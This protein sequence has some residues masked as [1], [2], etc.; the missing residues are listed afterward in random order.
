M[1]DQDVYSGFGL[2]V[3]SVAGYIYSLGLKGT[4]VSKLTSG[5][6]P[7]LIFIIIA[8]CGVGLIYQGWKRAD[9]KP[10]PSFA[11]N[12][13]IPMLIIFIIYALSL[14]FFK[15][16]I[17]SMLFMFVTMLF[18][19]ERKPVLLITIPIISSFGIYYLFTK[20]F[21]VVLP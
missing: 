18:L 8:L 3:F 17:G 6:F 2:L 9:K 21:L 14:Y 13:L 1:K 11:W 19:G 4:A 15:F 12:K 16:R 20:A 7:K 5:F 10:L